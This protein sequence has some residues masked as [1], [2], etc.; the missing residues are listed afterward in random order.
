MPAPLT[1]LQFRGGWDPTIN[2]PE[3]L[4]TTYESDGAQ[5]DAISGDYFIA[6]DSMLDSSW[7]KGDW[8]VFNGEEWKRIN[9]TGTVLSIFGRKPHVMPRAGD[10]NW[11]QI[12]KT[13]SSI[14]DF[15]DVLRPRFNLSNFEDHVLKWNQD[16]NQ[17]ELREDN[18]G[19]EGTCR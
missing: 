8:I 5:I 10:Y 13:G 4:E 11:S 15:R 18:K 6:T 17:F 7:N 1:G 16:E 2:T 12:D 3:I 9:N 19:A 14:F